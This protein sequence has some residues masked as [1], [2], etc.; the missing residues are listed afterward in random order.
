MLETQI[1]RINSVKL[2]KIETGPILKPLGRAYRDQPPLFHGPV[3]SEPTFNEAS[4]YLLDSFSGQLANRCTQTRSVA[5][6]GL[7]MRVL[8]PPST[9]R[10]HNGPREVGGKRA[11]TW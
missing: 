3:S 5:A 9:N 7:A 11:A 2:S 8:F 1:P 4:G 10:R 6:L